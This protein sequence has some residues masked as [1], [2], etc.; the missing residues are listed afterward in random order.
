MEQAVSLKVVMLVKESI[1][2]VIVVELGVY[3]PVS[4]LNVESLYS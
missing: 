3:V 1:G 4:G 2:E